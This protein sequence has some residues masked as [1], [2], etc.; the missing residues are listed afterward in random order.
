MTITKFCVIALTLLS[1][2]F[3]QAAPKTARKAIGNKRQG[4]VAARPAPS[5]SAKPIRSSLDP[6]NGMGGVESAN[7][8]ECSAKAPANRGDNTKV[9]PAKRTGNDWGTQLHNI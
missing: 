8:V 2:S 9:K 4:V 6:A 1:V 3:G 7:L 5:K